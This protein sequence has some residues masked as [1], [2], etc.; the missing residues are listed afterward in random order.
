MLDTVLLSKFLEVD[1]SN[2]LQWTKVVTTDFKGIRIKYF[3]NDEW[4][5]LTYYPLQERFFVEASLPKILFYKNYQMIYN[6]GQLED[7]LGKLSDMIQRKVHVKVGNPLQFST[8]KIDI[9]WNFIVNDV[10]E[11]LNY[12]SVLP[13]AYHG[14][15]IVFQNKTVTWKSC[16]EGLKFYDKF[17]E[18]KFEPDCKNMLRM[19]LRMMHQAHFRKELHKEDEYNVKLSDFTFNFFLDKLSFYL[20]SFFN[21]EKIEP[22]E[23]KEEETKP[24]DERFLSAMIEDYLKDLRIDKENRILR[25][26]LK[27]RNKEHLT[28]PKRSYYRYIKELRNINFGSYIKPLN[29]VQEFKDQVLLA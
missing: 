2:S 18:S 19:E 15:P 11:Y 26:L 17:L 6:Q 21:C 12:F 23:K 28:V 14:Y 9:C 25:F 13:L 20:T 8:N 4:M 1:T 27:L 7:A 22:N 5:R 10:D 24:E 16:T 3:C 29:I